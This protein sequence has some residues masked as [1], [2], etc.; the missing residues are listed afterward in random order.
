MQVASLEV[1]DLR[2]LEELRLEIDA[3]ITSIVGD[4]G[5]GKTNLLEAIYVGL[6][7]RS[8]RTRDRRELIRF[9][10]PVG[11]AEL[12]LRAED[13][14]LHSLLAS[15]SRSEGRRHLLDGEAATPDV[16]SGHRP[17]L[18]VFSPDRLVLVKGP[19]AELRAHVDR[20]IAARWPAR[21]GL[22]ND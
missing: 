18:V 12:A 10:C 15:V 2:T 7:G 9:G 5:A 19:P 17:H 20:F 11:R 14:A 1:R 22:R 6:S 3:G 4:N 13:G 8:F 21:A 16:I